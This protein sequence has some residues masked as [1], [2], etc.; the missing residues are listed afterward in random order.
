MFLA[1][2]WGFLLVVALVAFAVAGM[3]VTRRRLGLEVLKLNNEV[4]GFIYAV[5]GVLYAVVLGFTAIMVWERFDTAQA[6]VDQ[7]ANAL[8]DLASSLPELRAVGFNGKASARIGMP[9]LAGTKLALIALPSTSPATAAIPLAEKEKL[10]R[11]LGEF[12]R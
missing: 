6:G 7:E 9:Q 11:R 4:A 10:W 5:I 12:L 1:W 8:A 3:L 2:L